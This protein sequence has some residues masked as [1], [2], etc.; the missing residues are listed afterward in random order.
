MCCLEWIR[1]AELLPDA[2]TADI[3]LSA[4]V[5]A[6]FI[7]ESYKLWWEEWKEKLFMASAHV[8]WNLIDPEREIPDDAVSPFLMLNTSSTSNFIDNLSF[9]FYRSMI[10]HHR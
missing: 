7:T 4:W 9:C 1:V 2:N 5:P 6:S 3:D 10:W 8:Y